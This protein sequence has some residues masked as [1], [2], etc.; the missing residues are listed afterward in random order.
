MLPGAIISTIRHLQHKEFIDACIQIF[1]G[2][3][4][5]FAL[6]EMSQHL[7]FYRNQAKNR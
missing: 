1:F 3:L 6:V 2:T 7:K 5:L 4:W